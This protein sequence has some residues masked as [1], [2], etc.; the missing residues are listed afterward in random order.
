MVFTVAG[1]ILAA[2]RDETM[3]VLSV[4]F[5][6]ASRVFGQGLWSGWNTF[7]FFALTGT[8]INI[9][10]SNATCHSKIG[11]F[12]DICITMVEM[13]LIFFNLATKINVGHWNP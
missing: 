3:A 8:K 1:C 5:Y 6:T 7:N 2:Q 9:T 4:V 10:D 12:Q 11:G 13:K